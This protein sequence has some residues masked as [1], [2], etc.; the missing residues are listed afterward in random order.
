[1]ASAVNNI[2]SIFTV[3]GDMVIVFAV[4]VLI[5]YFFGYREKIRPLF[6]FFG[7]W[8]ILFAFAISLFSIGGSLIYSEI[9]GYNPCELCWF[10]RIFMYPQ[11]IILGLALLIRKR[12]VLPYSISLAVPGALVAGYHYLLQFGVVHGSLCDALDYTANCAQRL[13]ME[14]GYVTIPMMVLTAFL[15]IILAGVFGKLSNKD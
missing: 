13:V 5:A 11:V 1:M 9:I 6:D 12:D 8:S 4:A 3:F 14:F 10:Q 2:F 15:L 7:R